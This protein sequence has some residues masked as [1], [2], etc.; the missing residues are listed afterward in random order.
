MYKIIMKILYNKLRNFVLNYPYVFL[1]LPG[2]SF[3]IIFALIPLISS[4]IFSFYQNISG[5]YMRPAFTFENYRQ[6]LTSGFY[7]KNVLYTTLKLSFFATFL[8]IPLGYIIAY[9]LVKGR[10]RGRSWL[11]SLV[12]APLWITVVVRLF[13]WM[14]IFL[15]EGVLNQVLLKIRIIAEPIRFMATELGVLIVLTQISIPFI[16]LPLM[17]VLDSINP[18]LEEAAQNIGA[19]KVKTFL[20]VTLPLSMPGVIAGSLLVFALNVSSFVIPKFIGGGKVRM[21]GLM[22]Y[23][24]SMLLGN[25]PFASAMGVIILFVC[26]VFIIFYLLF[27]KKLFKGVHL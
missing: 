12:I 19:N 21:L 1:L 9:S 20:R 6:F 10:C 27:L 15:R 24:S 14:V 25:L 7:L 13:G 3:I 5:G 26:S 16:V 23:Q 2:V 8:A 11:I 18:E 22:V 17:G 4:F